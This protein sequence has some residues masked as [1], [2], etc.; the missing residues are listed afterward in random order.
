M[1]LGKLAPLFLVLSATLFAARF[2]IADIGRIVR[3][4]APQIAPDGKSIDK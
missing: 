4:A 1:R 3:L 2:G